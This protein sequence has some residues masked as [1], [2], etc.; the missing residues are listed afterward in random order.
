MTGPQ[1]RALTGA[2]EKD[3]ETEES[4]LGGLGLA[5]D[6]I[7]RAMRWIEIRGPFERPQYLCKYLCK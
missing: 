3:I 7:E 5:I 2:S 6:E 1:I 4:R